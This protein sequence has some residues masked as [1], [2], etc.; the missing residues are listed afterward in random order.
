MLVKRLSCLAL[1][2]AAWGVCAPASAAW[3]SVDPSSPL[4]SPAGVTYSPIADLAYYFNGVLVPQDPATIMADINGLGIAATSYVAGC[5]EPNA[6]CFNATQGLGGSGNTFDATVPYD[7]LAVHFGGGGPKGGGEL[8]FHW[9]S[10]I[11]PGTQFSISGLPQNFSNFRAYTAAV[12]EPETYGMLLAGL[13][14]LGL[15]RRRS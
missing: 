4:A 12:P 6:P 10:A 3:T 11:M 13:G 15:A 8:V 1:I 7:T 2:T 14:L 9:N 5:D